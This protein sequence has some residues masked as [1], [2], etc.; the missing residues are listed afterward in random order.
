MRTA[1]FDFALP[2]ELIAQT[3]A[4]T[5]DG[6]RLLVVDRRSGHVSH[7]QFTSLAQHLRA[8][9]VL[10]L[11]DSRVL[12]ARLRGRKPASGGQVELLLVEE[13]APNE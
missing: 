1:D 8:G 4:A 5:R 13:I 3:P 2:P 7:E 9:D 10:V 11:N 12:R 6:S